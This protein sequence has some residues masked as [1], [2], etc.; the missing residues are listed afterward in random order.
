MK[1]DEPCTNLTK[2]TLVVMECCVMKNHH[3]HQFFLLSS[4]GVG[5]LRLQALARKPKSK[6]IKKLQ[7]CSSFSII[8]YSNS[9][10]RS[11][12]LELH[13]SSP[14]YHL[15]QQLVVIVDISYFKLL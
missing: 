12:Y 14:L 11:K 10:R 15:L 2:K 1:I 4:V 3:H 5:G 6:V 7:F 9:R 8:D 13:P